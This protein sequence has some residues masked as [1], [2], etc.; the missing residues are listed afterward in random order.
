MADLQ[1]RSV[2]NQI[3]I[4]L[5]TLHI[6]SMHELEYDEYVALELSKL[7]NI[8][9]AIEKHSEKLQIE[10]GKLA[11]EA[12]ETHLERIKAENKAMYFEDCLV[13][14]K[15]D[16]SKYYPSF[17]KFSTIDEGRIEVLRLMSI[18]KKQPVLPV[19]IDEMRNNVHDAVEQLTELHQLLSDEESAI[20][21]LRESEIESK[22]KKDQE[23]EELIQK[24]HK[25]AEKFQTMHAENKIKRTK[26][27]EIE[28]LTLEKNAIIN[29][30]QNEINEKTIEL[31]NLV[32]TE[33]NLKNKRQQVRSKVSSMRDTEESLQSLRE[34]SAQ[35]SIE[36]AELKRVLEKEKAILNEKKDKVNKVMS[37]VEN[38]ENQ[39]EQL[40]DFYLPK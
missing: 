8:A 20:Q 16:L 15:M 28:K 21:K 35:L 22:K 36:E 12:K 4:F 37:K 13:H 25:A 1:S 23:Y 5:N 6:I 33:V 31:Q 7:R 17:P 26:I 3:K 24:L 40:I 14:T 32:T 39:L 18:Y 29:Q 9:N 10:K 19:S 30:L 38:E 2:E 11:I 34:E 27:K